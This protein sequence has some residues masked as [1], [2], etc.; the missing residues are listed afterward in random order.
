MGK[1]WIRDSLVISLQTSLSILYC[2]L[3]YDSAPNPCDAFLRKRATE[4]KG[5]VHKVE[6][7]SGAPGPLYT[8]GACKLVSL[9]SWCAKGNFRLCT[10]SLRCTVRALPEVQQGCDGGYQAQK[11]CALPFPLPPTFWPQCPRKWRNMCVPNL[12]YSL[13]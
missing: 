11:V 12:L 7:A 13:P 3:L 5:L 10:I 8:L 4:L 6:S 9:L 2:L 1:L